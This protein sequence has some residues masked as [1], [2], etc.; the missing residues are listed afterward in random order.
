MCLS[1]PCRHLLLLWRSNRPAPLP[2]LSLVSGLGFLEA[3]RK[4]PQFHR[5]Y[6]LMLGRMPG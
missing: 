5:H 3:D 2:C 4:M 6:D 1:N